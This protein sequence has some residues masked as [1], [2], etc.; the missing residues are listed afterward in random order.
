MLLHPV[1]LSRIVHV[2]Y[3]SIVTWTYKQPNKSIKQKYIYIYII[4]N[5]SLNDD[6]NSC[7]WIAQYKEIFLVFIV[8]ASLTHI[9]CFSI[10][11]K[12]EKPE[13]TR[14]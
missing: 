9:N 8:Y 5:Q 7:G 14:T 6:N 11:T 4:V 10:L 12:K 3:K 1:I 2:F 13:N